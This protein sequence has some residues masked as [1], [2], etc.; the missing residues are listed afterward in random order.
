MEV[1]RPLR[2]GVVLLLLP[3]LPVSQGG[4]SYSL[5]TSL[6]IA[7]SQVVFYDKGI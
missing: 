1:R 5:S 3:S 4:N 6:L 7:Q 2:W